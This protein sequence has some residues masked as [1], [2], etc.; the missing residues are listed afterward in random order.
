MAKKILIVDNDIQ[1]RELFYDLLTKKGYQVITA[2][3]GAEGVDYSAKESPDLVLLDI[4]MPGM[5]GIDTLRKI[6]AN[7]LSTKVVMLTGLEQSILENQARLSGAAGFL[8]KSLDIKVIMSII[9]EMFI[10]GNQQ[11]VAALGKSVL[12]VDDEPQIRSLLRDFLKKKGYNPQTAVDG[13]EALKMID[14][15]KPE[16]I[17]LDMRMPGM[18]GLETLKKIRE[19]NQKVGVIMITAVEDQTKAETAMR[20]GAY[21]YILKPIDLGYLD[22]CLLTKFFLSDT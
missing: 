18:D 3:G 9:D 1:V 7:N 17:L 15:V 4:N 11:H 21:D 10:P 8:R 12:V 2:A 16:M 22:L 19:V 13:N 6:K 5:D 14:E 20:L